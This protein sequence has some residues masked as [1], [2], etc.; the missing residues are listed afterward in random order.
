MASSKGNRVKLSTF[1][2]WGKGNI[3]GRKT[4][5]DEHGTQNVTFVWCLVCCR[6]EKSILADPKCKGKMRE[7]MMKYVTGTNSCRLI[8]KC[9]DR[10]SLF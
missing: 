2:S 10:H 3:I 1:S 9:F 5:T 7:E 6:N 8:A 4:E